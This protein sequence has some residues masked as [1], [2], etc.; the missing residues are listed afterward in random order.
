MAY[1][2]L[3]LACSTGV[4]ARYA[5]AAWMRDS[6]S[7]S[8]RADG[9]MGEMAAK[10]SS[11]AMIRATSLRNASAFFSEIKVRCAPTI[12][13]NKIIVGVGTNAPTGGV[14]SNSKQLTVLPSPGWYSSIWDRAF[15]GQGV[16]RN[17]SQPASCAPV[18]SHVWG[19]A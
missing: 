18:A 5:S 9:L 2:R 14:R 11:S 7:A 4:T 19:A 10:D 8:E 16:R 15:H 6:A 3:T 12:A 1:R 17:G 13:R